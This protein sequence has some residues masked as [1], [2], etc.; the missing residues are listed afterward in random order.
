MRRSIGRGAQTNEAVSKNLDVDSFLDPHPTNHFGVRDSAEASRLHDGPAPRRRVH[1]AAQVNAK[2]CWLR[3]PATKLTATNPF[4]SPAGVT[5]A[6]NPQ[7]ER[8]MPSVPRQSS[9]GESSATSRSSALPT[10][11]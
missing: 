4:N 8:S 10:H 5:T 6:V 3:A 9:A 7:S 1:A 11:I 2:Y